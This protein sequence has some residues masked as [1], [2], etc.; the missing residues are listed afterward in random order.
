MRDLEKLYQELQE[1]EENL[2]WLR[3]R[4]LVYTIVNGMSY[5]VENITYISISIKLSRN[6]R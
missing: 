1:I 5:C 6:E 3:K 2:K 4:I